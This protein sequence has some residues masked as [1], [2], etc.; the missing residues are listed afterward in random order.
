MWCRAVQLSKA[1][2]RGVVARLVE[3][4]VAA[5]VLSVTHGAVTSREQ[6]DEHRVQPWS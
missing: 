1:C 5:K 4:P 6:E 2:R 3:Q